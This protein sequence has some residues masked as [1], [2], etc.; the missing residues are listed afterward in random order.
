MVSSGAL[1]NVARAAAS[2]SPLDPVPWTVERPA[3]LRTVG[4][5]LASRDKL[6]WFWWVPRRARPLSLLATWVSLAG[7]GSTGKR[8][9]P[10]EGLICCGCEASLSPTCVATVPYW[11]QKRLRWSHVLLRDT[12]RVGKVPRTPAPIL[13]TARVGKVPR[14]PAPSPRSYELG[15]LLPYVCSWQCWSGW[16]SPLELTVGCAASLV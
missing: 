9:A 14:T 8:T 16:C 6:R 5:A 11:V 4:R 12:A 2:V 3:V 13:G 15:P 7:R 1:R 10:P